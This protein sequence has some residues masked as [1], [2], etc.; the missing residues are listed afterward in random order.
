MRKHILL[1]L[2]MG[3]FLSVPI[4]AQNIKKLKARTQ[5]LAMKLYQ[6]ELASWSST[7]LLL[8]SLEQKGDIFGGYLSYTQGEI[9]RA[10][11]YDNTQDKNVMYQVD[12]D[13][14]LIFK[15]KYV[16]DSTGRKPSAIENRLINA[17]ETARQVSIEN[18]DSIFKFYENTN[19]N[20][21]PLIDNNTITVYSLTGA[22]VGDQVL[23]GNDY[24]YEFDKKDK[25]V[26]VSPIHKTLLAFPYKGEDA[27]L[28]SITHSHIITEYP[29]ISGTDIC[30]LLLYK[31]FVEWNQ[32]VVISK[33]YVSVY[34]MQD[35]NLFCITRKAWDKINK[36]NSKEKD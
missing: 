14:I 35:N 27:K 9:T 15:D 23:L 31:D 1:T 32:C 8:P 33:K 25:L 24:K 36:R 10:I 18:K 3:S 13:D 17:R 20:Y 5:E 28:E 19:Y 12:Y 6:S 11:Y 30:T 4:S 2:I 7:D 29:I 26:S 34:N 21:I 22:T 16:I